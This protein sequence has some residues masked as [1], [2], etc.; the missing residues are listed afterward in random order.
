M[1]GE[2]LKALRIKANLTQEE[3]ARLVAMHKNTIYLYEN[4]KNVPVKK[5]DLL[6]ARLQQLITKEGL[7]IDHKNVIA[8]EGKEY[9]LQNSNGNKFI[10]KSDGS[11]DVT[12]KVIPF[13]AYASYIETLEDAS[14]HHDFEEV[15]FNVDQF[16]KG[17]YKAFR[18]KGDSMNGGSIDDVPDQAL[19][20]GRELGRHH[21]KD[22]FHKTKHGFIIL[23]KENIF[24]K[25][26]VDF[27]KETGDITCHSRNKSPEYSDFTIN[28]NDVYQIFKIIKRFM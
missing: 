13:E 5:A 17:N 7:S 18:I 4:K 20:L 15:L 8:D 9:S 14:V 19:V 22:G 23:C 28:L 21:W 3:L 2:E 27:D 1:T 16:G 26:I 10:L 24:H 25:D 6:R 11:Y 12:A